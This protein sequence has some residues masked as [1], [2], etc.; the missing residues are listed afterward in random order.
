MSQSIEIAYSIGDKVSV[1]AL[2][3]PAHVIS[4]M[5]DECGLSYKVVYWMDGSRKCEWLFAWELTP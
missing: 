4:V 2:K 3:E 1:S 5:L